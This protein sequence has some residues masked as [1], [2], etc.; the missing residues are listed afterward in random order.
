M[1]FKY[2]SYAHEQAEVGVRAEYTSIFDTFRRRMGEKIRFTI[3][4][5]KR[6]DTQA[7]LITKLNA[8]FT[9]YMEDY[10]DFG[11][12]LDDGVTPTNMVVSNAATFGG[13]KVVVPPSM[14]NG[15]WSGRPEFANQKTYYF[16]LEAETRVGEGIYAW[17]QR[18]VVKGTGGPKWRYSP[19]Q[20]GD[21]Q[22]QT[23]QT[24]TSFWYIQTGANIG[25]KDYYPAEAPLFP[26]IEH[27][28]MREVGYDSAREIRYPG[29]AEL[30]GTD[31]KYFM[32]ATVSQGFTSFLLPTL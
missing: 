30:F 22:V 31:W 25:R 20:V 17:K 7:A 5:V 4:G 11:L 19:R 12:Y 29:E 28:E 26:S 18:L 13:V 14:I 2:G 32:E 21:P 27:G 15:P 16:V 24:N 3:I 23:L 9:A 8:L 10:K 1:I 6:A